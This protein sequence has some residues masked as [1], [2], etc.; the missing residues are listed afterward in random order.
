MVYPAV[1]GALCAEMSRGLS[2][3]DAF[4]GMIPIIRSDEC[5]I[6]SDSHIV[7]TSNKIY[8][9]GYLALCL[10]MIIRILATL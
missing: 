9:G 6:I 1:S 10:W 8:G 7:T 2:G 3:Q 5:D 4:N